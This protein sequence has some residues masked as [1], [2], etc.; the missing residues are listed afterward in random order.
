MSAAGR[1]RRQSL[2]PI[3]YLDMTAFLSIQVALLFAFIATVNNW[4]D[5]PGNST[6]NPTANHP[7][8]MRGANREDAMILAVQ[9]DG[10]VWLGT[11]RVL[12]DELP[13]KIRECL[14]HGAERKIHINADRR[15]NYGQV[16]QVLCA[17]SS[18][19]IENVAFL[20]YQ[21]QPA[22]ANEVGG[23]PH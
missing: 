13:V 1:K 8:R 9:R 16:R 19:G 4:H 21:R 6:D 17:I 5:L 22:G 12:I 7:V 20:V 10:E 3:C 18:A 23:A 14:S 15:A 2:R 11:K